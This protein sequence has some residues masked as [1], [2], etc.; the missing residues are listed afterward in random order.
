MFKYLKKFHPV[1][2]VTRL[3]FVQWYVSYVIV[4]INADLKLYMYMC[5]GPT[6]WFAIGMYD[7]G[8]NLCLASWSC[9]TMVLYMRLDSILCEYW[10][11]VLMILV[12]RGES[13]WKI[14]LLF[15]KMNSMKTTVLYYGILSFT[16][17]KLKY[18]YI[19]SKMPIENCIHIVLS[20]FLVLLKWRR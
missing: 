16:S 1:A 8:K 12:S 14:Y 6:I 3:Y 5:I 19:S 7:C 18:I 13:Y 20:W 4:V 10:C 11:Q 9:Q 15:M 2:L 17:I